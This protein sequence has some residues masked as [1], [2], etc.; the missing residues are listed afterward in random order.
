M[1]QSSFNPIPSRERAAQ[2]TLR[3]AS[4][5]D[6]DAEVIGIAVGQ[7][8]AVPSELGLDRDQLAA[9]SFK[10]EA[11]QTL[12]IPQDG[13]A[14]KVAVGV[15]SSGELDGATLR[16]AAAAFGRATRSFS[17]ALLDLRA[18]SGLSAEEAGRAA[19]EGLLLSRYFYH[20]LKSGPAPTTIAELVLIVEDNDVNQ[21]LAGAQK[22]RV[23][24][25]AASLARDLSNTPPAYLTATRIAE[26][27]ETLADECDLVVE[28]F[29]KVALQELGCGGL[30]GVNAGSIEPPRM[31]KMTYTPKEESHG[32]LAI[33]GK[34]VMYDSGGISLKPSNA[35]HA[36]MKADM[37]GAGS[38]FAAMTALSALGCPTRV[39]AY[40]MCTDNMP[41]GSALKL[42]DVLTIYGGKTVEVMNTDAEGR[43]VMADA[44]VLA[45]EEKPDAIVDIST[46]TGACLMALGTLSAGVFGNDDNLVGQI[47]DAADYTDETVWQLP[48]DHRYRDQLDSDVADLK[49]LGGE[50][51]GATT[52][53]LFLHEFVGDTPW[54]HLDIAG[55][56]FLSAEHT[57]RTKG[58]T[59]Y[60][61]RLLI[62]L[63]NSFSSPKA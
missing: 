9:L 11:G 31:V 2:F 19:T 63:A 38:T 18:I 39:T 49:N 53:A 15:G 51:A 57:W 27:A 14:P 61:T 35:S 20:Q 60:G 42:G 28:T 62:E 25:E 4:T 13:S 47:Q 17:S 21:A 59:G 29:D 33:V 24:A 26:L 1:S 58:A 43:I 30:L 12:L 40:L 34:G 5:P 56:A 44:L 16:D 23:L 8:G 50:F 46:L 36:T 22:G 32:H 52:A 37:S 7:D 3:V 55:P 10:G 54:A 48:L 6:G 45:T 41:S